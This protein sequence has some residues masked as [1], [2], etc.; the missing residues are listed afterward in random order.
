[1]LPYSSGVQKPEMAFS[2]WKS[3]CLLGCTAFGGVRF[4]PCLFQLLEVSRM[5]WLMALSFIF[6]ASTVACN[7]SLTLTLNLVIMENSLLLCTEHIHK[8]QGLVYVYSWERALFCLPKLENPVKIF[9]KNKDNIKKVTE[10]KSQ[11]LHL[12]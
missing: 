3:R 2:G 8:F 7:L 9:F 4:F 1:M 5:P 12:Q 10:T 6:K 11:R